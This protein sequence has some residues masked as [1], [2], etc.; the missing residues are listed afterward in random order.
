MNLSFELFPIFH[1]V[2]V[3][4]TQGGW[5]A[6][7]RVG[8][9]KSTT[10]KK[11]AVQPAPVKKLPLTFQRLVDTWLLPVMFVAIGSVIVWAI[12]RH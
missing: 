11:G 5:P 6:E 9:M 12:W 1:V 10:A 3:L 7:S 4:D 2:Q 8:L